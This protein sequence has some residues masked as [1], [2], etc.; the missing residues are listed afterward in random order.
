MNILIYINV[1]VFIH[2]LGVDWRKVA[3]NKLT[4]VHCTA[5]QHV[6]TRCNTL[7]HASTHG[8]TLQHK[9]GVNRW[10][11][12]RTEL[13]ATLCNIL[14]HNT[15]QHAA[16]RCNTLQHIA[17]YCNILQYTAMHC[18]TLQHTAT[19]YNTYLESTD[20]SLR[21]ISS[22]HFYTLTPLLC[23]AVCCS[24]MQWVAVC[25]SVLQCVAVCGR[26]LQCA[27]VC[28]SVLQRDCELQCIVGRAVQY[29]MV[30][31]FTL[32]LYPYALQWV[33]ASC[34]GLQWIAV[35]CSEL[36]WVAVSCSELQWVA[37]SCSLSSSL[38]LHPDAIP[39]CCSEL[40]RVAMSCSE[41]QWLAVAYNELK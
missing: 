38:H 25:C 31:I 35:S 34:S 36:Q 30:I 6:A 40:Q 37:V 21:W 39:V 41:M 28:C 33:S 9:F 3:L 18:N 22:D 26:A 7:Q 14:P 29:I 4:T 10:E 5:L 12:A 17:T 19:H 13:T 8:S 32:C 20:E 27:A 2:V 23:V 11:I 1:Y 24:S 16:T 15:L